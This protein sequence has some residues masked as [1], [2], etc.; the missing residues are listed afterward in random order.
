MRIG[1]TA[2]HTELEI[3]KLRTKGVESIYSIV[4]EPPVASFKTF[5]SRYKDEK[6][7]VVNLD[8]LGEGIAL[9]QLVGVLLM[10]KTQDIDLVFIEKGAADKLS[11]SEYVDFLYELACHEHRS[12]SVRTSKGLERALE[13]G[14]CLGRPTINEAIVQ[15]ILSLV[16]FEKKTYRNVAKICHV[17][18]G[19]VHKY[20]NMYKIHD[21]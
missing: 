5:L 9:I 12:V 13:N 20:V 1:Y 16:Y 3:T 6:L 14:V 8:S 18:V 21:T 2:T 4:E 10:I 11:D 17:S 19:T 15:K 7:V